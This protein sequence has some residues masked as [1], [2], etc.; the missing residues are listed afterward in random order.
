MGASILAHESLSEVLS[1][2]LTKGQEPPG[3]RVEAGAS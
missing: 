2:V 3:V 1:L